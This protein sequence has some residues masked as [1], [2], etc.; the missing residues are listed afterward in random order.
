MFKKIMIVVAVV[1]AL[2]VVLGIFVALQPSTFRVERSA[3]M[4]APPEAVFAE[5]N[6]LHRWEKWSP[7]Q[8]LDPNAR[9]T[10][11]GPPAGVGAVCR[12]AGNSDVGEGSMTIVESKP[13]ELIRVRLD[14]VKPFEDTATVEFAFQPEGAKTRVTWSMHGDNHFIG[15]AMCLF[16]NLDRMIGDKYEEG[17][18]NLKTI[19][20]ES[21][22]Q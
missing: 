9:M 11:E 12:W 22:K 1:V 13:H 14:F 15:K 20:E 4:A 7:W 5:V 17:L 2:L 21:P 19:V 10:Y 3:V 16:M 8:K 18:A 6:D